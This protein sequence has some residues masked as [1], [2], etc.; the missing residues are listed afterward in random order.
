[1]GLLMVG[2][3]G[4]AL[5]F[6]VHREKAGGAVMVNH[7]QKEEL[8]RA[9]LF[10]LQ[11]LCVDIDGRNVGSEGNRAATRFFAREMA[12]FGW[13]TE[14]TAFEALDWEDGGASLQIKSEAFEVFV[15]PFSENMATQQIT[16]TPKD[17]LEIVDARKLVDLAAAIADLVAAA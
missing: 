6:F 8:Y 11:T 15:S 3:Q 1:M 14:I 16:H 7:N 2:K 10:Y 12:A 5:A 17:N 4:A 13:E 9:A